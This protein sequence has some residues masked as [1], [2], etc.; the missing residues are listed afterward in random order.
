MGS[1]L[2]D[3]PLPLTAQYYLNTTVGFTI[4]TAD[5]CTTA[6]KLAF[7]NYQSNLTPARPA[8]ATRASPGASGVGLRGARRRELA[9]RSDRR[10]PGT[11]I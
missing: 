6:P 1:E 2:L 5:S 11:S 7:S 8:C 9:V 3:L 4:N 10:E